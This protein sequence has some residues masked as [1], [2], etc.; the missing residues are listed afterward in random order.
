M[1]FCLHC[2]IMKGVSVA[3]AKSNCST[4][5]KYRKRIK[6]VIEL[7]CLMHILQAL[8]SVSTIILLSPLNNNDLLLKAKQLM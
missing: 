8:I 6:E 2:V 4:K 7:H 1:P 3:S 5:V